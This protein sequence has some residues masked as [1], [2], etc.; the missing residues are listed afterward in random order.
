M[1]SGQDASMLLSLEVFC[2]K[3]QGNSQTPL[4]GICL[5]S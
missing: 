1:G 2:Q 5:S 3:S 4:P